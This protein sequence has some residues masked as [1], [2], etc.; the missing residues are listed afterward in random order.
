M[1][2]ISNYPTD[3]VTFAKFNKSVRMASERLDDIRAAGSEI[4]LL[5]DLMGKNK[6]GNLEAF[7]AKKVE[8]LNAINALKA[9]VE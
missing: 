7:N 3:I 5:I 2:S 4:C 6:L 1:E 8:T 9:K